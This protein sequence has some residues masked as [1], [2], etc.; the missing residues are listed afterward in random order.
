[1]SY[2]SFKKDKLLIEGWRKYLT[3]EEKAEPE[4]SGMSITD[5]TSFTE[6]S[7]PAT[8]VKFMQE[9]L[10]GGDLFAQLQKAQYSTKKKKQEW[11]TTKSVEELKGWISGLGDGDVN[12]GIKVFAQRAAAVGKKIPSSGIPKKDMPFLP[13]PPD[14][15]GNVKDV[16]DALQP[17]GKL[18]VDLM[19]KTDPPP[20]NTFVGMKSPEAQKFMTGGHK[21]NDGDAEDDMLKIELGGGIIASEAI[22]TQSNILIPKGMGMA[23]K[24][25]SGGNLDA[26]GGLN[27]EILDGHH[28]WSA[29]MLNDPGAEIGTVARIDLD[30]LGRNETLKYLTAIGNALGNATKVN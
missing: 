4:S 25:L 2:S 14:A 24:G 15:T 26:Y 13:G 28:R 17:G 1:M 22:P 16:E 9:L 7:D 3:E 27:G 30:T 18:N 12:K 6:L 8:G 20:A 10:K 23:I 5:Q 19:E 21:A 29:T 11:F